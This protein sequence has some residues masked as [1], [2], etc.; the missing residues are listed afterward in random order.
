MLEES[1]ILGLVES[2][3]LQDAATAIDSRSHPS[4][5]LKV[6]RCKLE[7]HV[8]SPSVSKHRAEAMLG[9]K[10]TKAERASCLE[11]I[12]RASLGA[13]ETAYGVRALR[14]SVGLATEANDAQLAARTQASLTE[15][16]LHWVG[17]EPAAAEM[18]TLRRMAVH[19][20]DSFSI[21]T[22]HCCASEI[23]TKR[24]SLSQARFHYLTATELLSRFPNVWQQGRLAITGA[25]LAMINS[26]YQ[27]AL[28]LTQQ[29]LECADKSGSRELRFPAFGNLAHIYMTTAST[30]RCDEAVR[31]MLRLV[32]RGGPSEIPAREMQMHVAIA[33]GDID[34]AQIIADEIA[35]LSMSLN[36]GH[37]DYGM[38]HLLTRVKW[39]YRLGNATG[40]VAIAMEALPAIE[41]M[42][43]RNLLERMKVLA[44]DGLGRVGRAIEGA[45]LL[46][47]AVS[48]NPTPSLEMVAEAA[49]VAGRLC[50]L[51]D[52]AAA[53]S[54]FDRAARILHTIGHLAGLAEIESDVKSTIGEALLPST[55]ISISPSTGATGWALSA[56][57]TPDQ[58]QPA[59]FLVERLA[60]LNDLATHPPLLGAEVV[61]LIADTGAAST[62]A[63][64]QAHPI[65][66]LDAVTTAVN[67]TA[68]AYTIHFRLGNYQE[69]EWV[70]VAVSRESP[71]AR[72]TLLA[73][74]RLVQGALALAKARQ[75]EREQALMWP[76]LTPEQELGLVCA[77]ESMRE[78]IK[79]LRRVATSDVSVLITGETG[80]GKEL[81]AR[82]LHQAS[83]RHAKVFQ[84]FNCSTV[85]RDMIDS[86]LFGYRRGAFTGANT[87]FTGLIRSAAGGTLFLD[88]VGEMSV[89]VQPKLLRFL[90]SGEILPLGESRPQF[91]DVR[92]VA[93][94]N[95]NLDE[96]VTAGKFREDLYYRLNVV[97]LRVPPLRERREEIPLLIEYF[98]DRHSREMQR[99]LLR[100]SEDA[101]EFLILYRWPGNVRQL[102]NEVRRLVALAEPGTVV[103]PEHLSSEIFASRRSL[104]ASERR[105]DCSETLVRLDQPLAAATEHVERTLIQAALV[106]SNGNFEEAARYLGLSRKGL[107]L[108][109]QRLAI[110]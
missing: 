104:P 47:E 32:R 48:T 65:G 99:P 58:R 100:V 110:P 44:A 72:A 57:R 51:D 11:T 4:T 18:A 67:A 1:Q 85:P 101:L 29:A 33:R 7:G 10:L 25:G 61:A 74:E 13:G 16:F 68:N 82:A 59:A 108:K 30:D 70:V 90:E 64:I 71:G 42:G 83:T 19:A 76:T 89:E 96:L 73:V 84:P 9:A 107:Y 43:D 49:R 38:W 63:T 40:G 21:V 79:T 94:T 52:A 53:R 69:R 98:M 31:E 26:D 78:L 36:H 5:S 102:S 3:L 54:H 91:A 60:L 106:R 93:A 86:Q 80:V 81:F 15:A 27:S 39:L 35:S 12:G 17:I 75:A 103:M 45:T 28:A 105:L 22:M 56:A 66:H 109:R 14:Q 2:G 24:R 20:G 37:S 77:A 95:A 97:P 34:S 87:D 88:E 92:V 8:G 55:H 23:H 41:R 62:I 6:L 46:A 50:A